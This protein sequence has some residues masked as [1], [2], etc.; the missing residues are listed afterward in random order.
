MK[1]LSHTEADLKKRVAFKKTCTL[2]IFEMF[3]N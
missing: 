2:L 3:E 1:K